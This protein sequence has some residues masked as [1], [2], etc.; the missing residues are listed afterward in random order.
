M[1]KLV[2]YLKSLRKN[3]NILASSKTTLLMRLFP[4][5]WVRRH[6]LNFQIICIPIRSLQ[7][8]VIIF[9]TKCGNKIICQLSANKI[10]KVSPARATNE[11]PFVCKVTKC[12]QMYYNTYPEEMV[13]FKIWQVFVSNF[14]SENSPKGT[15]THTEL[16]ITKKPHKFKD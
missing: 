15:R 8:L 14:P 4:F 11:D 13:K 6:Y 10:C 3:D 2:P 7:A 16:K 1:H 12:F 5:K 9:G